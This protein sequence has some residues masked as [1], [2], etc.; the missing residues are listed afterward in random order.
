MEKKKPFEVSRIA[1]FVA[2]IQTVLFL[3]HWFLY[4][5]WTALLGGARPFANFRLCR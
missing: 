3:A 5:T 4:K 1:I 2:V